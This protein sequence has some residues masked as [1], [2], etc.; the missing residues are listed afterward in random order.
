[1]RQSNALMPETQV[2]LSELVFPSDRVQIHRTRLAF[3]HLDNLL[4]FA[5]IDRDGRL[6]G[7]ISAYL[8]DQVVL[9]LLRRGEV[10]NAVSYQEGGR[11]VIPIAQGL[12]DIREEL[13][14]GELAY[15]NA[16]VEQLSWMFASC[17]GAAKRRFVD[18]RDPTKL[19]PALHHELFSGVLELISSGRV[20]YLRFEDG[21]FM[22]GYYCGKTEQVTVPQYV[23]SLFLAAAD[24][25]RPPIAAFAFGATN[26]LP[27]QASPAMIETYRDLF[28]RIAEASEKEMPG[29]AIKRAYKIRDALAAGHRAL[30]V[31]GTPR[32]REA[33]PLVTTADELTLSLADWCKGLL[34]ELE[35]VSPGIAPTV[36]G[37]ATREQ[38]FML[39][40]AGFFTRLPWTVRW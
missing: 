21:K 8:P 31:I 1:M 14:R 2:R 32:D 27:E 38:R 29:E 10:V 22:N 39:Q 6:D 19:F 5:K 40:K 37:N 13:E 23:E 4:H 33:G 30:P 20:T 34:E 26:E 16:P 18:E 12:R 25:S 17:T 35:V 9:L 7:Y 36:L 11:Q 24:G 28:W 3:I 15:G